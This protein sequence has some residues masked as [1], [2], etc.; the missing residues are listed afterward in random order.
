[1]I[2]AHQTFD[3][4]GAV[5]AALTE[6]G[7]PAET[8]CLTHPC[9]VATCHKERRHAALCAMPRLNPIIVQELRSSL[10][11]TDHDAFYTPTSCIRSLIS[12][13]LSLY[14][15]RLHMRRKPQSELEMYFCGTEEPRE[16]T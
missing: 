12:P 4:D 16:T 2:T 5:Q 1:M 7:L 13:D 6:L 10:G 9:T 15:L 8:L 14:L 11:N 3:S